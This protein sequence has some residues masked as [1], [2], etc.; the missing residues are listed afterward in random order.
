MS[1]RLCAMSFTAFFNFSSQGTYLEMRPGKIVHQGFVSPNQ[2]QRATLYHMIS[3]PWETRQ[4]ST[5][6]KA[7]S[8]KTRLGEQH[9]TDAWSSNALVA[10]LQMLLV[11]SCRNNMTSNAFFNSSH[12]VN[13]A[14][15]CTLLRKTKCTM[16]ESGL[17][18]PFSWP[19]GWC[20]HFRA[21]LTTDRWD[22]RPFCQIF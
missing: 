10:L 11:G 8:V 14:S 3:V 5:Y 18:I 16:H 2:T 7:L 4:N 12:L 20:G 13:F 21:Y 17:N 19:I 15:N 9:A 22:Q 1:T 6:I